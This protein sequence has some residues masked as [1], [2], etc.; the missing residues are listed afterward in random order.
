MASV[1]STIIMAS[2]LRGAA[3]R[4]R[5]ERFNSF[6]I[7]KWIF[8]QEETERREGF[9]FTKGGIGGWALPAESILC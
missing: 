8:E 3:G 7:V 1:V 6:A 2:V 4:R 5:A 9:L